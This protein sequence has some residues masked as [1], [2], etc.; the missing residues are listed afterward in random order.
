MAGQKPF[1]LYTDGASVFYTT[2]GVHFNS[3]G[4]GGAVA[5]SDWRRAMFAFAAA[6]YPTVNSDYMIDMNQG[7]AGDYALV[8]NNNGTAN[9]L[10]TSNMGVI[11]IDTGASTLINTSCF[12]TGKGNPVIFANQKTGAPWF[13]SSHAQITAQPTNTALIHPIAI[14]T[15]TSPFGLG[16]PAVGYHGATSTANWSYYDGGTWTN[17]GHAATFGSY[18]DFAVGFDGV[19][20]TFFV[21]S[22]TAGTLASIGATTVLTNIQANT[23]QPG[24]IIF[25]GDTTRI[26]MNIDCLYA[27]G[28]RS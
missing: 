2:D 4:G 27:A 8:E 28:A 11:Q 9:L 18:L 16:S 17:S 15:T 6:L 21:G 23:G 5:S 25:T 1:P 7:V 20:M 13:V 10:S 24:C 3:L 26:L 19:T 12:M 22:V 14:T